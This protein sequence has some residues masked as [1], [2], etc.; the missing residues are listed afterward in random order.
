M[1]SVMLFLITDCIFIQ[2]SISGCLIN[3]LYAVS[4]GQVYVISNFNRKVRI[5]FATTVYAHDCNN[6][7]LAKSTSSRHHKIIAY[8]LHC[9][10]EYHLHVQ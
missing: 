3:R 6:L 10:H 4:M 2:H 8:I 9:I 1:V 5:L 7:Y